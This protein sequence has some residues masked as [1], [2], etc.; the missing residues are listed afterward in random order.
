MKHEAPSATSRAHRGL[1]KPCYLPARG[2]YKTCLTPPG[3]TALTTA[4]ANGRRYSPSGDQRRGSLGTHGEGSYFRNLDRLLAHSG[5]RR[6]AHVR[7][8]PRPAGGVTPHRHPSP[9]PKCHLCPCAA[10]LHL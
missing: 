4:V 6:A 5:R 1:L 9:R 8:L 2:H 7:R 3:V 10:L